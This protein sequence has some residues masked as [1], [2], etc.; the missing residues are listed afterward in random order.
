MKKYI[1]MG[2]AFVQ[3]GSDMSF[4]NSG[5]RARSAFVRGLVAPS[6]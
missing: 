6:P 1:G 3:G 2:A 4:I 5:A